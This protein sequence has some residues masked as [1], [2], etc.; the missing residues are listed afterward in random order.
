MSPLPELSRFHI[1][2]LNAKR[3]PIIESEAELYRRYHCEPVCVEADTTEQ[4]I[5]HIVDCDALHVVSD[6]LPKHLIESLSRCRV[7][8]RMGAGTDKIDVATATQRGIVVTNVPMFCVA[9]QANYAM[10]LLL[11]L[12]RKLPRM[13]GA[14]RSGTFR[15]STLESMKN[16]RLSECVL[17]LVG[18]GH[19][20][21]ATAHRAQAFGMKIL[22]TRRTLNSAP[23]TK[24]DD[25]VEMVDLNTLLRTSDY[26]SLHVPLTEQTH[27]LIDAEA[28]RLMKPTAFIINTARGAV[29]D[30]SALVDA[31]RE[32]RIAG[33]GLD[34]YESI[35]VFGQTDNSPPT[36][37]LF[38]LDNVILTPH[39]ASFSHE[40]RQDVTRG[41]IENV[42]A[43]LQGYWPREDNIVNREVVP[44]IQLAPYREDLF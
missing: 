7:I 34:V 31:L 6:A 16:R 26:V 23:N 10:L 14:M 8:S 35:D 12:A 32:G 13:L 3:F 42:A 40:A 17:G 36:H 37:P 33:A 25:E 28:L 5:S 20:A 24:K 9:E 19:T 4:I 18:F 41:A 1:V 39:V 15:K 27:H 11:A 29:I 21:K 22:A 38:N 30:E 44:R 2:R 43:I